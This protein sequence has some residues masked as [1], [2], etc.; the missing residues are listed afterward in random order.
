M[1]TFILETSEQVWKRAGSESVTRPATGSDEKKVHFADLTWTEAQAALTSPRR[2]VLL[3][4]VGATEAHGPHLPLRTDPLIS[5]GMCRRAVA[6]LR[7][8]PDVRPLI[9]PTLSFTV[10]RYAGGFAGTVHVS[11]DTLRSMVVDVCRSLIGQGF[12]RIV[13][14]NNHFEPEH[15][16]TLHRAV[17]EVEAATEVT[18]G[19]L[20]L[21]RKER[22]RRLTEE[23][24][25]LGSHAGQYE[26]SL[27][28]A[29]A[30]ELVNSEVLRSLPAVDVN[31]VKAISGGLKDFR[32]M[33]MAQAYNGTPAKA[34]REEGESSYE[35]LTEMLVE[36]IRQVAFGSGGRDQPGLYSRV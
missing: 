21:T 15:V 16:Q 23:F 10:T 19:Y 29:D 12:R 3:F 28:L 5:L 8:D 9:L 26:A 36:V 2:P 18:V 13:I 1:S 4:P 32:E 25:R 35:A 31:L 22:A 14:V 30:P 6:A 7:D 27:V 20:D 34:T 24:W 11:E 17:D 33:G